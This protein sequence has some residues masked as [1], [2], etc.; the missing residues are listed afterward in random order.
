M[1]TI[2]PIPKP[3]PKKKPLIQAKPRPALTGKRKAAIEAYVLLRC[4]NK[5]HA[6]AIID[7]TIRTERLDPDELYA[8][9]EKAGYRYMSRIKRWFHSQPA[10]RIRQMARENGYNA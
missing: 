1:A 2:P 10:E 4:K 3:K 8:R 9:L 6:Q 5:M 7:Q